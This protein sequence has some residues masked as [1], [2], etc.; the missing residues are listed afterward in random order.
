MRVL[1]VYAHPEPTSF[2]AALKDEAVRTI[3]E[4][5]HGVTVSDLY[6]DAF[7]PVAGRHDFTTVADATRFH[8][9]S[10][11]LH[12]AERDTF[13]PD[14]RR[15]QQR[16]AESDALVFL[17]PLWWGGPPAI[18]KGWIDRVLAY[19]VAYVDGARFDTGLLRE[20]R[21]L[22]CVTTGGTPA[23]FSQGGAYGDIAQ[24]L[25]PLQR[26][27]L[28]YMGLACEEPFI[29][30]GA[31]RVGPQGRAGYLDAWRERLRQLLAK[32]TLGASTRTSPAPRPAA[33]DDAAPWALDG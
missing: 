10:E 26:L 31:P 15:E 18:V 32:P 29:C 19:G 13:A 4:A 17:F 33:L 7:D 16:L 12:A 6:A 25:W 27:T 21:G 2:C 5:G 11:Q 24:V 30:Y 3:T 23:R 8:Y 28:D 22:L 1:I 14:I 9:Q 20:K